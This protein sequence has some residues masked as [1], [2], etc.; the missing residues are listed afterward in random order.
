MNVVKHWQK[1]REQAP[2]LNVE[3]DINNLTLDNHLFQ[4]RQFGQGRFDVFLGIGVVFQLAA[5]VFVVRRHIA[6]AVAA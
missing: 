2:G 1:L 6:Q 3:H 5:K 4:H